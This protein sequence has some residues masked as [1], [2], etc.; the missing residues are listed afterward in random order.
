MTS[1]IK[2]EADNSSVSLDWGTSSSSLSVKLG[3]STAS[4]VQVDHKSFLVFVVKPSEL[5]TIVVRITN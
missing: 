3:P 5:L 2:N 1:S 4:S